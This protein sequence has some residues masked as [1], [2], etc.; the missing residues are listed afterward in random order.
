MN[1]NKFSPDKLR[2]KQMVGMRE[3]RGNAI[4]LQIPVTKTNKDKDRENH[5]KSDLFGNTEA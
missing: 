4:Q 5:D 2:A 3:I 1:K